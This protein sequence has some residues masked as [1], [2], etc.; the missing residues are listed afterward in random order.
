V[1]LVIMTLAVNIA[2]E[3]VL[4]RTQRSLVGLK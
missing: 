1:I 3:A 4:R 2:G